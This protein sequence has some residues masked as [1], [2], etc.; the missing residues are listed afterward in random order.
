M[1]IPT[2]KHARRAAAPIL[3]HRIVAFADPVNSSEITTAAAPTDPLCGTTGKFDGA[4]AA[5]AM[6]DRTLAGLGD[7]QLGGVVKA[8][9]ALTSDATGKAVATTTAG[10]RIIG[11]AEEPGVADDIIDYHAAP[12]VFVGAV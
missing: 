3:A 9:D 12:G 6:V 5:G 4:S 10:H 7:V 11:F 8:G 2:F 1:S